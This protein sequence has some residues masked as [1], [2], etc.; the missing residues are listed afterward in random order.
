MLSKRKYS[1][2]R[3]SEIF[4]YDVVQKKRRRT[5]FDE[6]CKVAALVPYKD[7]MTEFVGEQNIGIS[8]RTYPVP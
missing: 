1:A 5:E 3:S 8:L 6:G 4:D 7:L 2:V